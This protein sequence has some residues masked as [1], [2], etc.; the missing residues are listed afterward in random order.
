MPSEPIEVRC[1]DG[2]V[3]RGEIR[4]P[5]GETHAVAVVSHAMMVD[6]RTLDRPRGRGLVSH[7][8]D[9][10]IAVVTA[11]LRG[12]GQS[13]PRAADGGDWGYD[14]LVEHDVPALLSHA[15]ARFP[16]LPRFAVGHSLFGH[17][18]L[19]HLAR[20]PDTELDGLVMIAGNV[21]NPEW[22][23]RPLSRWKKG[24]LI[25]AMHALVAVRGFF[26]TRR[27]KRGTDDEAARYVGD[28]ARMWRLSD[29]RSRD[30]FS[31]AA[32]LPQVRTPLCA[33]VS[34]GDT[35]YSP[36]ADVRGVL[37]GVGGPVEIIEV[38][39]ASGL[40]FDPDH[41]QLVLD[42][43]MRPA[44]DHAVQFMLRR[45]RTAPA[46]PSERAR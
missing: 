10:G 2:W 39:T 42:E 1:S 43:K 22:R 37:A 6:R 30:G 23:R 29:W 17:V 31:Y 35:L 34:P 7:L 40:P 41:M 13:G 24:V 4:E 18:T 9:H 36:P 19:A 38:G 11:D 45:A 46:A 28:M 27:L 21:A 20:Y 8:V 33:I 14:D 3:L 32:A 25:E 15:A 5:A 16:A 26:P 12:H 44:W